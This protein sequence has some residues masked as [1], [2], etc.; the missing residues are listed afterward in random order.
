MTS[1]LRQLGLGE[2]TGIDV[3]NEFIGIVPTPEWKL[4]RYG[5]QWYMGDT[6]IT[7]IGQG[8]FLVTPM[9]IARYTALF[10]TGFLPTPHLIKNMGQK[11]ISIAPKDVLSD[12]QKSKLAPIATGMYQ[13]C[14][15]PNGGTAYWRTR[16]SK[17]TL[18]CKTGT[19]QVV[20]IPQDQHRRIK[21]ED[22]EYFHRSHGWITAFLPYNNPKY[23]ITIL[24]EHGGSGSANG[25]I[26]SNLANALYDY[27]YVDN[28][29][30]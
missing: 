5:E 11:S 17:V 8:A 29:K 23:V 27:G 7:S 3:P 25:E 1:V 18:A 22:M 2:K 10:A 15:D 9:Q 12:F 24:V 21:E 28:G 20:S 19:A 14:N 6:I 26:L 13:V 30:K 4:R 16:E